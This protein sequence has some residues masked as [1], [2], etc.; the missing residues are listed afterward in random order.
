MYP[1]LYLK[2]ITNKDL[3][4]NPLPVYYS[5]PLPFLPLQL[6]LLLFLVTLTTKETI[7][8]AGF[9]GTQTPYADPVEAVYPAATPLFLLVHQI[10]V[11]GYSVLR[12]GR[13][14]QKEDGF[15]WSC[16]SHSTLPG[17]VKN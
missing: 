5:Y 10:Q 17:L 2:W 3:P 11:S 8:P 6:F 13:L 14:S 4:Y 16:R 12:Q 7:Y 1:L 9:T 15:H